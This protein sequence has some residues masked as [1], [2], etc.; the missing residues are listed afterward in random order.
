MFSMTRSLLAAQREASQRVA[1]AEKF[2]I[3][4]PIVG[5]LRVPPPD[6]LAFW[7]VLG[8]LVVLELIDWPVALAMGIGQAVVARHLSDLEAREEQLE[9][10]ARP[11]APAPRTLAADVRTSSTP[12][13]R[14]SFS[15]SAGRRR[16]I[17][18][19]AP[20]FGRGLRVLPAD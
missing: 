6:Q 15:Q 2:S 10:N 5:R 11:S 20:P 8:G 19:V 18:D 14:S 16:I 1:E 9:A 13:E 17:G 12:R 7:G 3:Q 4:L